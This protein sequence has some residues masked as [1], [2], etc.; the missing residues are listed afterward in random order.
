MNKNLVFSDYVVFIIYFLIV[1]TYGIWIYRRKK[2]KATDTKDFF[3]AEGTL[4]WWAIGASLIASNI[5]AEQFVGMSGDGFFAGIAVAAYEWI[6]AVEESGPDAAAFA[7]LAEVA[8]LQGL[9]DDARTLA[10]EALELEPGHHLAE[11]VLAAVD[12]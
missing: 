6:A 3:L 12:A 2:K 10:T 5:S 11:R 8:R 9:A 7:G 1:A 4:T